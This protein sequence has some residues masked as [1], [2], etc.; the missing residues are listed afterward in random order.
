MASLSVPSRGKT[1]TT[2]SSAT[3]C[4]ESHS[5]LQEVSQVPAVAAT[6]DSVI[7]L[8]VYQHILEVE[9]SLPRKLILWK[10]SFLHEVTKPRQWNARS[11]RGGQSVDPHLI[12]AEN[13]TCL[14]H[15]TNLSCCHH[16]RELLD[17]PT[18]VRLVPT[19]PVQ[20]RADLRPTNKHLSRLQ[21][22]RLQWESWMMDY[23][24]LQWIRHCTQK[25]MVLQACSVQIIII[26]PC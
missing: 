26:N 22:E 13:V 1:A 8:P 15:N 23:E 25:S 3:G 24:S 16:S 17:A 12:P 7:K 11:A 20:E 19:N 21:S 14:S 10:W 18:N 6:N 4:S 2:E 5:P 9:L